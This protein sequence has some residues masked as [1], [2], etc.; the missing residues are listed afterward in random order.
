VAESRET[1]TRVAGRDERF[2][3]HPYALVVFRG[4]LYCIGKN[5]DAGRV[6][7]FSF[8]GIAEAAPS[9]KRRFVVP[10]D[11]NL[12]AY[13]HGPFGVHAPD[14]LQRVT[15]EFDVSTAPEIRSR[16]WHATQRIATAPDGRVRLTFLIS[17][18]DAVL[19]WVLGYG[20]HARV[21]EPPAL[22]EAMQEELRL[23]L[24]RYDTA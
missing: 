19:S 4:D 3:L 17:D 16:K 23:A 11:F 7:V 12:A 1:K 18:L 21:I 10:D 22:L 24:A 2:V 9:E 6:E 13:V 14:A 8:D 20:Q 5:I 15:V